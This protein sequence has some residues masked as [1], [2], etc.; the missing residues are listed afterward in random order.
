MYVHMNMKV[1]RGQKMELAPLELELQVIVSCP[2]WCWEP[3]HK[4]ST[5][6]WLQSHLSSPEDFIFKRS[7]IIL[8]YNL[9]SET[10][11]SLLGA[12][13]TKPKYKTFQPTSQSGNHSAKLQAVIN[14]VTLYSFSVALFHSCIRKGIQKRSPIR[15]TSW[16]GSW[17][18]PPE[19]YKTVLASLGEETEGNFLWIVACTI[20]ALSVSLL[21]STGMVLG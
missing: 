13:V 9:Y 15:K 14:F 21:T 18:R 11:H 20:V 6:S 7:L 2:T 4:S 5:S 8:R 17:L 3:Y 12:E 16:S 19:C 10:Y 1:N